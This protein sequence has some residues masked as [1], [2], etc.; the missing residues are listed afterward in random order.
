MA[1]AIDLFAGMGGFSTG[2]AAAGINVLWAANHWPDAV[3]WH[4]RNHPGTL[5]VCQDLH[6]AR[7]A[8]VP[9]HDI[10]LASP[11][12]HG[13]SRARGKRRNNPEH[14]D[15][16]STAWAII[17]AA[18]YHRQPLWVIENVPDF[19]EWELYP[20]F[21]LAM[22]TLGYS[23][24]PHRV[25]VADLGVPQHRERLFI[26]CTRS[27]SPLWLDLPTVPHQGA[28][29]FI[30]FAAGR[31]SAVDKPGRAAATLARVKAGRARF[32][33]RFLA[34]YYGNGSGRTGR[35]LARPIGTITTRD[36]WAVVD[37]ARMRMLTKEENAAGMGF[38][39]STLLP[40]NHKLAV[41]MLG[42]AV[43]PLAACR[44]LEAALTSA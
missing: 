42:N 4:A 16:R 22:E 19:L 2:A 37:G 30:D 34:P 41:H 13:H 24:A 27:R 29:T 8:E 26:V 31:W 36:R 17:A 7:W 43:P 1:Q 9:Q 3:K 10:G 5:H 38:P 25:D 12:C 15:S 11:C 23:L 21:K 35:D 33:S 44:I 40:D 14:D 6:Q 18:E 20:A 28:D 39:K 32:G